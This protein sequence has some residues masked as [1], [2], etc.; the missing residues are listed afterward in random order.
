MFKKDNNNLNKQL[1]NKNNN[2]KLKKMKENLK[3]KSFIQNQ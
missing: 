1:N 2:N 3:N